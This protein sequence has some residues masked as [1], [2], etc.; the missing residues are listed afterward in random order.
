MYLNVNN[1][2][3]SEILVL[4]STFSDVQ[5]SPNFVCGYIVLRIRFECNRHYIAS[6]KLKVLIGSSIDVRFDAGAAS[7][8]DCDFGCTH[9]NYSWWLNWH[10]GISFYRLHS[11]DSPLNWANGDVVVSLFLYWRC[12]Q[13][14]KHRFGNESYN[15]IASIQNKAWLEKILHENIFENY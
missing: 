12:S 14:S 5:I 3:S 4:G 6:F 15:A 11:I 8:V 10:H 1:D 13:R 2:F 9:K 7:L